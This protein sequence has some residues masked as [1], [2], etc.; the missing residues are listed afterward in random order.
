MSVLIWPQKLTDFW[1]CNKK[2]KCLMGYTIF[3]SF[4]AAGSSSKF[5]KKGFKNSASH[6]SFGPLY[7]VRALSLFHLLYSST[8]TMECRSWR[9]NLIKILSENQNWIIRSVNIFWLL[10]HMSFQL[11]WKQ[12]E[13]WYYLR[14]F[15]LGLNT[16]KNFEFWY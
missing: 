4:F 5:K 11:G 12:F 9:V 3:E 10:H 14:S 1:L 6:Q 8:S 15:Q 2:A 13:F 16:N 7:F